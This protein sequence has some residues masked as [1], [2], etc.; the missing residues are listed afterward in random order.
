MRRI[1]PQPRHP[2]TV[3]GAVRTDARGHRRL[4]DSFPSPIPVRDPRLGGVAS[5][6]RDWHAPR[7]R[8][9]MPQT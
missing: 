3:M 8:P 5:V 1:L 6:I 2:P 9:G 7:G 4:T